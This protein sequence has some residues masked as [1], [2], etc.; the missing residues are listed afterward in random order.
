MRI[1]ELDAGLWRKVTDFYDAILPA[2]GAPY[3]HGRNLNAL[4][5]SMVFG[6]VNALDPPYAVRIVNT[7]NLP[8]D[9]K[10]E[11]VRAGEMVKEAREDRHLRTGIDVEVTLEL[12]KGPSK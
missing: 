3:W 2:I 1:I 5:D 7:D 8:D 6:G 11:T 4:V 12:S 9:V 10:A